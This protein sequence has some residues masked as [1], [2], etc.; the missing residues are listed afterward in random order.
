M[1]TIAGAAGAVT[2]FAPLAAGVA[3]KSLIVLGTAFLATVVLGK[4]SAAARHMVWALAMAALLALPL[5]NVALPEWPVAGA[6]PALVERSAAP[7]EIGEATGLLADADVIDVLVEA[8]VLE[9]IGGAPWERPVASSVSSGGWSAATDT[10]AAVGTAA[11]RRVSSA[12]SKWAKTSE[13]SGRIRRVDGASAAAAGGSRSYRPGWATVAMGVWAVGALVLVGLLLVQVI[14]ARL[15]QRRSREL[16]GGPVAWQAARLA[17]DLGI[18]RRVRVL[19]GGPE[20]MP[21]TWGVARPVVLVPASASEW[22]LERLRAVLL[23]ELAHVRRGDYSVQLAAEL[24]CAL[25]WFNPLVWLAAR[26]LR[27]EREHACD[28]A[29]LRAGARASAYA[30]DL[31]EI[32]RSLRE[33]HGTALAGVSMARPSQ[34]HG[35]LLA[36][37]DNERSRA[38]VSTRLALPAC[39]LA[40]ALVLPL[41]AAEP[42][43]AMDDEDPPAA[44]ASHEDAAA[45]DDPG[46]ASSRES[47]AE[48]EPSTRPADEFG[49]PVSPAGRS[50][51][52][53][54]L[55]SQTQSCWDSQGRGV[56][57]QHVVNNGVRRLRVSSPNCSAEILVEGDLRFTQD[58]TGIAWISPGGIF[59]ATEEEGRDRREVVARPAADGVDVSW[60]INGRTEAFDDEAAQWL[61]ETLLTF[62]RRTGYAADERV[63]WLLGRGGPDA[64]LEEIA[65]LQS[66]SA[67][68][69]YTEGL[70]RR[71]TLDSETLIRV[72]RD[73]SRQITSNSQLAGVLAAIGERY[74]F[75]GD[76]ARAFVDATGAI[77]SNSSRAA[78]LVSLAER[79]PIGGEIARAYLD[80]ARGISSS[81]QQ[82]RVL[83]AALDGDPPPE[84]VVE[85]LRSAEEI[86]SNSQKRDLLIDVARRHRLEGEIAE[87][88]LRAANTITSNSSL[89]QA[90]SPVLDQGIQSS[91]HVSAVLR[92]ANR[93]SSSSQRAALLAEVARF[94]LSDPE[95]Q[96]QYLHAVTGIS[97][98]SAKRQALSAIVA[99]DQLRPEELAM[100]LMA[101]RTISS[102]S[103]LGDLLVEI[104]EK[105][106]L[107]GPLR[108]AYLDAAESISSRSN[109][110]RAINALLR[111][112]GTSAADR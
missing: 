4:A 90:L 54:W 85:V 44:F 13:G 55:A 42:G 7:A 104:A 98:S 71:E 5:L 96:R 15:V 40:L 105:H 35:R 26:R 16:T 38:G 9:S 47:A 80:V 20:A 74:A 53:G 64:V 100:V 78:L 89:R 63:Q 23:H 67:R 107:E 79:H 61:S 39:T 109:Y 66:N 99:Q 76:V 28:N 65:L 49:T 21:M 2:D 27:L 58:F 52:A 111:Q 60:F 43:Q 102:N 93:I 6:L 72:M 68:R 1:E 22:P 75:E 3:L 11:G 45:E 82:R 29:V 59:R 112:E 110:G 103:Q 88:Y 41:A 94:D 12:V 95:L 97:S 92:G 77:S 73:S 46:G 86:S 69:A 31:L 101:A 50:S 36:L 57:T 18:T 48:H 70:I 30:Q 56:S 87:A 19:E 14:R 10:E 24:A 83:A 25:Y 33:A 62:F 32:A 91:D 84:L 51:A 34:L 17:A 37:L 106:R 108:D 8:S 81:S